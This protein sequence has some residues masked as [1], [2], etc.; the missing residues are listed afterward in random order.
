M[1]AQEERGDI[2]P[3]NLNLSSR[4]RWVV[5]FRQQSLYPWA[6]TAWYPL[7]RRLAGPQT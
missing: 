1:K 5:S 7:D 3:C 4:W 6:K 2:V